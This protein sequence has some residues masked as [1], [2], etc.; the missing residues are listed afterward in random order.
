[1][2]E[3]SRQDWLA[4]RDHLQVVL[5][6]FA[7]VLARRPFDNRDGLRGVSALALYYYLKRLQPSVV[8]EVGVWRGFSTWLIEQAAPDAKVYCFDPLF[9]LEPLIPKRRL[10][11]TYRSA[12]ATYVRE[13]FSCA[14]LSE[15]VVPGRTAAFFDDHQRKIARLRQARDLGITD[16]VFDDNTPYAGTHR[17]L[18]NDLDDPVTRA[19]VADLIEEYEVFPALWDVDH[20]HGENRIVEEGLGLPVERRHRVV[21][22]DRGWHS[23]VTY[24]RLADRATSR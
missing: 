12:R 21:Y 8:L 1:M 2:R 14:D 13:E 10:R 5:D 7:E 15:V 16:V 23:Y 18:Q 9:Y 6:E 3:K 22:D 4:E 20:T 24:V 17:S 11:A 19:P